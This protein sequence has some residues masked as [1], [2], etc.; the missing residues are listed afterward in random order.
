MSNL[1]QAACQF[2]SRPDDSVQVL[3]E[4]RC[5]VCAKCQ[6]SPGIRRLLVENSKF[7]DDSTTKQ[8]RNEELAKLQNNAGVACSA[9]SGTCP[10]CLAPIAQSML[11]IIETYRDALKTQAEDQANVCYRDYLLNL[12]LTRTC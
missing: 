7:R 8:F 6:S 5:L 4:S 10:I 2:C 1:Q 9:I 3:C 12:V 11:L